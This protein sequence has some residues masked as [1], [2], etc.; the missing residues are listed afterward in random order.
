MNAYSANAF[1]TAALTLANTIGSFAVITT[2]AGSQL[3]PFATSMSEVNKKSNH[4]N[5]HWKNLISK[6]KNTLE[7]GG[8][9]FKIVAPGRHQAVSVCETIVHWLKEL[10][11]KFNYLKKRGLLHTPSSI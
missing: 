4:L 6:N 2:D 9:I 11:S 10:L 3:K 8:V 1:L 7:K 5:D